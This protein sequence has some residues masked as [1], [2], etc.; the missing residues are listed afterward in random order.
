MLHTELNR[1][2][3]EDVITEE[4][5]VRGTNHV[6]IARRA[7][8]VAALADGATLA[9]L[10]ALLGEGV[11]FYRCGPAIAF[12]VS[13][14]Q[15][16]E[17]II[18]RLS[19]VPGLDLVDQTDAHVLITLS[20]PDVRRLLAKAVPLDL[21]GQAFSIGQSA[22]TLCGQ[23]AVQLSRTALDAFELLVPTSYAGFLLEEIRQMGREF[24]FTIGFDQAT[25]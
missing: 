20:G 12:A 2:P 17:D 24:A 4:N 10:P 21:H 8:V 5:P 22:G 16:V 9:L 1:H 15:R 6:S 14:S 7:I 25:A 18:E 19:A 3:L 11:R 23:V 13:Q